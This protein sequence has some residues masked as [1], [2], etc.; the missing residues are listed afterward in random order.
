MRFTFS[1]V[2]KHIW[3]NEQILG[4]EIRVSVNMMWAPREVENS[5]LL[6]LG[7]RPQVPVRMSRSC[8]F[9]SRKASIAAQIVYV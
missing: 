8:E 6:L 3:G 5:R 4:Y 1:V 7:V 9:R 2:Q